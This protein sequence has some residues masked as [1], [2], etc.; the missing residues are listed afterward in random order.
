[1]II[2]VGKCGGGNLTDKFKK[3][4][5]INI[6]SSVKIKK[7]HC[8]DC[9]IEEIKKSDHIALLIRDPI[10]RF[11]S[12]FYFY[13]YMMKDNSYFKNFKTPSE[14][15]ES[16]DSE[17]QKIK[18][19][20]LNFFKNCSHLKYNFK[21]YLSDKKIKIISTKKVFVIRQ[22]HYK[23]DFKIYYEFLIKKFNLENKF[24]DFFVSIKNNTNKYNDLK[25]LSEKAI[26]NLKK[27]MS[28]DYEVL[29]KLHE[30]NLI[31]EEYLNSLT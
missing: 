13:K 11:V 1:M 30:Y 12:I 25:T 9:R 2:H 4:H 18:N 7:I 29:N 21:F 28:S 19:E 8:E 22:E 27:K 14:L 26:S 16:L 23:E 10:T 15:A 24:D 5:N 20:A 6:R 3:L 17:N 31:S